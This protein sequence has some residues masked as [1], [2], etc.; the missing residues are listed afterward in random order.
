MSSC[1]PMVDSQQNHAAFEV[2][3]YCYTSFQ[4]GQSL[5]DDLHEIEDAGKAGIKREHL[6]GG[7]AL[8]TASLICSYNH[9]CRLTKA[10]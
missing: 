4:K 5:C 6:T 3:T 7:M 2:A 9:E 1:A 8:R 10:R